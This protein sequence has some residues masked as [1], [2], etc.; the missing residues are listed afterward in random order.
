MIIQL[1]L[2]LTA[3]ISV[4]VCVISVCYILVITEIQFNV[5]CVVGVVVANI[6]VV[7]NLL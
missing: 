4:C 5:I 1:V 3:D 6:I 7:I 2:L